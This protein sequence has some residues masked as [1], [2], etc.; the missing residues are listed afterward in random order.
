MP[1]KAVRLAMGGHFGHCASTGRS[2]RCNNSV[3]LK[4]HASSDIQPETGYFFHTEIVK[5]HQIGKKVHGCK[6][7]N[8]GGLQ[9]ELKALPSRFLRLALSCENCVFPVDCEL[10]TL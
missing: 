4:S 9:S 7:T 3:M 2:G 5:Y 10:D 6:E 8:I 1:V